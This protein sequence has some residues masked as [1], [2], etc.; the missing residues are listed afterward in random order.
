MRSKYKGGVLLTTIL[1][2]FLFSFIFILILEDFQLTQ[3]FTKNTKEYYTAKTMVS[4]FL[5]E[6]KRER[7]PLANKGNQ[8]F[9]VG[10]LDYEYDGMAITCV[11]QLNNRVYKFKESY[12]KAKK[13]ETDSKNKSE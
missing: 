12:Q 6:V 5:Y 8:A 2:V 7:Q 10:T 4:M 1:L 9:S 13:E 3:R 11:V